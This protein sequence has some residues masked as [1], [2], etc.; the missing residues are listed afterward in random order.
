VI[1]DGDDNP[2]SPES[3]ENQS[4]R[5]QPDLGDN[6]SFARSSKSQPQNNKK[7]FQVPSEIMKQLEKNQFKER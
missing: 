1:N 3:I 7:A 6:K 4:N 5:S 2:D